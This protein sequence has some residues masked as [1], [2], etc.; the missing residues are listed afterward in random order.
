MWIR[1]APLQDVSSMF[2]AE[3]SRQKQLR[4]LNQLNAATAIINQNRSLAVMGIQLERTVYKIPS[5][6][7]RNLI[8]WQDRPAELHHN[9]NKLHEIPI[10]WHILKSGGTTM[11]LM[12]ATCYNLVEAC[13]TGGWIEAIAREEEKLNRLK[14]EE[15]LLEKQIKHENEHQQLDVPNEVAIDA[16]QD[17]IQK[18]QEIMFANLMQQQNSEQQESRQNN[19]LRFLQEQW[20][21][22]QTPQEPEQQQQPKMPLRI[23]DSGDGRKYVNVDVTTPSGIQNAFERGFVSSNLADVIFTPMLIDA[24]TKLL[25]GDQKKGRL[26]AVF[27]HPVDRVVSTFVSFLAHGSQIH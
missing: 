7:D 15:V 10:F 20:Q 5:V 3:T 27:R 25:D 6:L 22:W 21:L 13:E 19:P 18:S 26:F 9:T 2:H 14:A 1:S 11:K 24:T 23:V 12:Y 4:R 8:N 16:H 17:E